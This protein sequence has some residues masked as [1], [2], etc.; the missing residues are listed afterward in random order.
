MNPAPRGKEE[1]DD[2]TDGDMLPG[3]LAVGAV[4]TDEKRLEMALAPPP[5]RF[6]AA[7]GEEGTPPNDDNDDTDEDEED[8]GD[9]GTRLERPP[10]PPTLPP[11]LRTPRG[12][13]PYESCL[14]IT[15]FRNF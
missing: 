12:E 8:S 1:D 9:T 4:G 3:K 6:E 15:I 13:P 11:L 5:F 10:P 2:E 14:A 7:M